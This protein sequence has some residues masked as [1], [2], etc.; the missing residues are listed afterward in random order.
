MNLRDNRRLNRTAAASL[1]AITL[2]G[3][4]LRLLY[5]SSKSL[6]LDEGFSLHLA[7]TSSSEFFSTLWRSEL[8]MT[9]Y[10][11]LLRCW[12]HLGSSEFSIRVLSVLF[13]V[14][15]I[16]VVFSLA[17]RLF[18]RGTAVFSALLLALHPFH[19]S[20]SQAA[21]G[22]A[23]A[24]LLCSGSSLFFVRLLDEP[25]PWN[26]FLYA[27]LSAL[28]IYSQFFAALVIV[29]QWLSFP[30]LRRSLP[31]KALL[32]SATAFT[33]LL[34]PLLLFLLHG[35]H[36]QIAW[37]QPLSREQVLSVISALTLPNARSL[38]YVVLWISAVAA[39][40][41]LSKTSGE[42]WSFWFCASW[43]GV[44]FV[45]TVLLSLLQP[46]MVSRFLSIS[47]PAAVLLAAA[48][49]DFLLRTSRVTMTLLLAIA[50]FFSVSAIRFYYR[51]RDLNEDWRT[52][53]AYV[54]ANA[55]DG[56]Q[57]VV[58]PAYARYTFD[59]YRE[60]ALTSS[61]SVFVTSD[62]S[63]ISGDNG[64][65]NLWIVRSGFVKDNTEADAHI[66]ASYC[67]R[68]EHD[69]A[70]VKVQLLTS[71]SDRARDR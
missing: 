52:A 40:V 56:D 23:L 46:A 71:C 48:G 59:Y 51:H 20:L 36:S 57:V 10:Y 14:A 24:I 12:F 13:G 65:R 62:S 60:G 19:L 4:L 8:N 30:A 18:G 25:T 61:P 27:L 41:R 6:S 54:L 58:L 2:L 55:G 53:T 22:Y 38:A 66:F 69:F 21:R 32:R 70:A 68:S 50:L 16:P 35:V 26:G 37:V 29:A 33:I 31:W 47:V 44:P 11:A 1:G 43:L 28:A 49:L 45:F 3:A 42:V 9:L 63:H 15:T 39:A 64:S 7:Q 67:S 5:V 17:Q 34:I